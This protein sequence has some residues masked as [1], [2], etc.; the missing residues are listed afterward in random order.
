MSLIIATGSNQGESLKYLKDVRDILASHYPLIAESRVYCSKA[1]DYENQP[2]FFNQV[3]EFTL[4]ASTPEEVMT[5]LLRIEKDLGRT[6]VILRGPR[7]IDID[8]IFWGLEKINS[9]HLTVPHP[10][11][12]ERSFVV[13]PLQEL[14]FFQTIEKCFTIPRSFDIEASPI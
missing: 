11:W 6:R 3:L 2:D 14:P 10:R 7:T 9:Q 5:N 12:S 8:I 1:V 13:R 4:P